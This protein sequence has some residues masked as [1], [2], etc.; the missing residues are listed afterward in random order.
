MRL[1]CAIH[2]YENL[3]IESLKLK[4]KKHAQIASK[5][6]WGLLDAAST[7]G[8]G[9][10]SILNPWNVEDEKSGNQSGSSSSSS[11]VTSRRSSIDSVPSTPKIIRQPSRYQ[12]HYT[13]LPIYAEI[14]PQCETYL[15][16]MLDIQP[17]L[18][19]PPIDPIPLEKWFV[20]RV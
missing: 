5:I 9:I 17:G 8:A 6:M 12:R 16:S 11:A 7:V 13:K 14:G 2:R 10:Y 3:N 4:R 15:K 1:A 19:P 20:K 18:I